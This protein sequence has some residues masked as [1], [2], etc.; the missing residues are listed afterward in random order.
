MKQGTPEHWKTL[1]LADGLDELVGGFVGVDAATVAVGLLERLWHWCGQY[2]Q[3]GALR[4]SGRRLA[5]AVGWMGDARGLVEALVGAGFL[6]REGDVLLV[7]DWADHCEDRVHMAMARAGKLFADGRRPK[8]GRIATAERADIEARLDAAESERG[9]GARGGA[10]VSADVVRTDGDGECAP[11][12]PKP[13]PTPKPTLSDGEGAWTGKPKRERN[14]EREL[15]SNARELFEV[16]V[17][18]DRNDEGYVDVPLQTVGNRAGLNLGQ[19]RAAVFE[20][21]RAKLITAFVPGEEEG[22]LEAIYRERCLFEV[23]KV[24]AGASMNG[25]VAGA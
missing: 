24:D 13:T 23:L 1:A 20:L 17:A 12:I 22:N 5:A 21:R 10:S 16:I 11:P 15:S 9:A 6:D 19:A 7:H 14:G 18:C 25:A 3:D 4:I 2:A 8:L